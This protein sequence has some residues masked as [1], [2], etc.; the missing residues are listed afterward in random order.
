MLRS[1]LAVV[2]GYFVMAMSV[3]VLFALRLGGAEDTRA[4]LVKLV[5][6]TAFAAV[7]GYLTALI[8][9][10]SEM[11]HAAVLAGIML[12]LGVISVLL[13]VEPLWYRI[14]D[15]SAEVLAILLGGYA[16]VWQVQRARG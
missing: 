11:V 15:A 4:L 13:S 9:Q 16:R 2:V 3:R 14:T 7:A 5:Y 12:L 8:A 1:L 10:R 6:G